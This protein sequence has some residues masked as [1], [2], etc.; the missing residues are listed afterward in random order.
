[1]HFVMFTFVC[2][3]DGVGQAVPEQCSEVH[4]FKNEC[5]PEAT[6]TYF[7]IYFLMG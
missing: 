4:F 6:G 7:N 1:M 2:V 5:F 3:C